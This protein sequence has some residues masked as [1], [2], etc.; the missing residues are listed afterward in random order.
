MH[1]SVEDVH[2]SETEVVDDLEIAI[3]L[4]KDGVNQ[5][6][7]VCFLVGEQVRVSGTFMVEELTK[8]HGCWP[9]TSAAAN[10]VPT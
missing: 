8:E 10:D 2:E 6:R 4:L 5:R 1:V 3:D 7:F 9:P